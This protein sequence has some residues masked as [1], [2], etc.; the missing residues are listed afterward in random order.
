MAC[1]TGEGKTSPPSRG[2]GSKLCNRRQY[3]RCQRSP[4]SRGRGSKRQCRH[5]IVG[6][7][8]RLLHG[9]GDRNVDGPKLAFGALRLLLNRGGGRNSR[10][11]E[12]IAAAA[13]SP[14][15]KTGGRHST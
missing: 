13:G 4:P 3:D 5:I 12:S 14:S 9:G 7:F 8:S 1:G 6:P 11:R 15:T 10:A 2:R